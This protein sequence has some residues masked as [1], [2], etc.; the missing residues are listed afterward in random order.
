MSVFSWAARRFLAGGIAALIGGTTVLVCIDGF[1]HSRWLDAGLSWGEFFGFLLARFPILGREVLGF[2]LV[3]GC[4]G[5][6]ARMRDKREWLGLSSVGVQP[7]RVAGAAALACGGLAVFLGLV[8]EVWIAGGRMLPTDVSVVDSADDWI[9]LDD[10]MVSVG[11]VQKEGLSNTQIVYARDGRI[12]G[13]AEGVE[14]SFIDGSWK[15]FEGRYLEVGPNGEWLSG[16][17]EFVS[18]P[19]P[20]VLA[21]AAGSRSLSELSLL[22]LHRLD[23]PRARAWWHLRLAM[24]LA[25]LAWCW[26]LV[27]RIFRASG[28]TPWLVLSASVQVGATQLGLILLAAVGVPSGWIWLAFAGFVLAPSA[29]AIGAIRPGRRGLVSPKG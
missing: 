2:F 13:M 20:D 23:N 9:L 28:K 25:P 4:V 29:L 19:A 22:D 10:A 24:L 21:L 12:A 15:A 7:Y 16:P 3:V 27:C 1:E 18:L 6:A 14:A 8:L 26:G 17:L 5:V 11:Q